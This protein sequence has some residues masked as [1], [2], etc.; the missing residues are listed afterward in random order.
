MEIEKVLFH[1]KARDGQVLVRK[2][3]TDDTGRKF[4]LTLGF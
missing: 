2:H 3:Y 1:L 4:N